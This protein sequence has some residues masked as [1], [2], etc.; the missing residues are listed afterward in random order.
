MQCSPSK[1]HIHTADAESIRLTTPQRSLRDEIA[2]LQLFLQMVE[3]Q[4]PEVCNCIVSYQIMQIRRTPGMLMYAA[5]TRSKYQ[6][7]GGSM[8][9]AR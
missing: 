8:H 9:N 5:D 3:L 4:I 2:R 7:G 1:V 6:E